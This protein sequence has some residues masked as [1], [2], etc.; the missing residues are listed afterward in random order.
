MNFT[1]IQYFLIAAEEMSFTRAAERL[2]ITQQS[3]SGRIAKLEQQLEVRL[4][5][6][7][8]PMILTEAGAFFQ[9]RAKVIYSMQEQTLEGL[10]DIRDFRRGSLKIGILNN[11]GAHVLPETITKFHKIYPQ[12]KLHFLE[13]PSLALQEALQKGQINLAIDYSVRGRRSQS[14]KRTII[15]RTIC[16]GSSE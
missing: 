9:E 11:Q 8:N 10:D 16:S 3:L 5:E 13:A 6:R 12:I 4:F 15:Y 1:D 7:G 2:H 14:R